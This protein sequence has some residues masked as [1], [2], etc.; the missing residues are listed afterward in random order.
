MRA[1]S[2]ALSPPPSFSFSKEIGTTRIKVIIL[3][4]KT[5]DRKKPQKQEKKEMKHMITI[6]IPYVRGLSE[7]IG[8][9][10]KIQYKSHSYIF[11]DN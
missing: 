1:K 4:K 3:Y 11:Q 8:K 5:L 7:K 6:S 9:S 10:V 2:L